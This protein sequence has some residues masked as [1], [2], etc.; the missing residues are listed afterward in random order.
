MGKDTAKKDTVEKEETVEKADEIPN[1]RNGTVEQIGNVTQ[2][3]VFV[4]SQIDLVEQL[5]NKVI[6]GKLET[7][8]QKR[9]CSS[10]R[11]FQS[12]NKQRRFRYRCER[13]RSQL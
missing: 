10:S 6:N 12:Q 9:G 13:L 3:L 7:D 4:K 2:N 5:C 11:K 1:D 8:I